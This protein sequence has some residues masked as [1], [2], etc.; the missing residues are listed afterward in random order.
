MDKPAMISFPKELLLA[1][2]ERADVIIDFGAFPA[3]TQFILYNSAR[4]P[5]PK[6]APVDPNTTGQIMKFVVGAGPVTDPSYNPATGV[7]PRLVPMVPLAPTL[8]QP[9]TP[10]KIRQLTLNEVM[11][12]GGPLEVLLNNT[13]WDGMHSPNAGGDTELP[14]VGSTEVWEI[15][16]ITADAH[17][18][19]LHLVQFQLLNRQRFQTN[20]YL[21]AYNAAFPAVTFHGVNYPG[22][23][24]VPAYGPPMAYDPGTPGAILGGNPDITPYLQGKVMPPAPNEAGW[25]DTAIMYPGEVTRIVV[26]WAALDA[27]AGAPV[28]GVNTYPFDPTLDPGYVWHCHILDHEDNEMMRPYKVQS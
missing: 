12:P 2:G 5:Y 24:F 6:G 11:G 19:H 8:G 9:N 28:P 23:V 18:I 3:G 26:R 27:P 21:K 1:P 13:K 16:N 20:K 17:P 22:G 25:K 15:I 10:L 7:S 4:A 14:R